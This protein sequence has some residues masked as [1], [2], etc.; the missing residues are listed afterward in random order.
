V[1]GRE[2]DDAHESEHGLILR[3]PDPL[4]LV[5]VTVLGLVLVLVLAPVHVLGPLCSCSSSIYVRARSS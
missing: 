1:H 3:G 5:L 2:N 4:V